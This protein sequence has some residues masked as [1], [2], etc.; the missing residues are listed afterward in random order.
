MPETVETQ[1]ALVVPP[2]PPGRSRWLDVWDPENPTFWDRTG[3]KVA[4]RNLI[5]SIFTEHIGF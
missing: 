2:P 3:A 1:K 5:F 4:R